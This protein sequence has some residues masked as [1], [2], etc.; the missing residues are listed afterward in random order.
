MKTWMFV[1]SVMGFVSVSAAQDLPQN[2]VPSLVLNAFQ[3]KY[4]NATD[5]EWKLKDGLYQAEFEVDTKD[6]NL[7]IDKNGTVKKHKEDFPKAQLPVAIREKIENE[8]KDY[9]IDDVDR[10]EADGK[11]SFLV[12]LDGKPEDREVLFNIDGTI[13]ENRID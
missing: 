6:H 10:L 8:F 13:Q 1:M 7:W 3:S 12:D 11:V 4:T 2:Q 9:R 5:V